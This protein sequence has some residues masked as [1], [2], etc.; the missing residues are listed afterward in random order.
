VSLNV[1]AD[2]IEN[3]NKYGKAPSWEGLKEYKRMYNKEE[4]KEHPN[5]KNKKIVNGIIENEFIHIQEN[6]ELDFTKNNIDYGQA[7]LMTEIIYKALKKNMTDKQRDLLD[8]LYS[9]INNEAIELCRFYFRE[10][11]KAG[12]VNLEFLKEIDN[13][14]C[15]IE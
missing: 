15:Y 8:E 6:N 5:I 11:V 13:I 2:Y 3:C 14:E 9:S 12:L 4:K 10:G 7:E 1:F